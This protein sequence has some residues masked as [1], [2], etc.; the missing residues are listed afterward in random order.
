MN[1]RIR[2][3]ALCVLSSLQLANTSAAQTLQLGAAQFSD[4]GEE[5][6]TSID[7]TQ[8]IC[9]PVDENNDGI[10]ESFT[11]E[12]FSDSSVSI[13]LYNRGTVSAFVRGIS[14]TVPR[15]TS[16]GK[17]L[18]SKWLAP[19]S[20]PTVPPGDAGTLV[21]FLVFD[22]ASGLKYVPGKSQNFPSNLGFRN[23]TIRLR[24]VSARATSFNL[25]LK[26]ALSFDNFNRCG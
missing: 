16:D 20:D 18:R 13:M 3:I 23:V 5:A 26:H 22:A 19:I 9:D 25:S 1:T 2:L 11:P 14:I 7:V 24:G 21:K 12:T 10:F 8:D 6:T 4:G 15:A 17:T